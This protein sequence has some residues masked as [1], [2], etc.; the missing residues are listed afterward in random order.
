MFYIVS[1][2]YS[3]NPILFLFEVQENIK[4]NKSSNL[5]VIYIYIT[6]STFLY[7]FISIYIWHIFVLFE[8]YEA[9]SEFSDDSTIR[10]SK[11]PTS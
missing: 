5:S 10:T 8:T 3:F 7:I 4:E 2:I 11:A 9:L 6:I 1:S